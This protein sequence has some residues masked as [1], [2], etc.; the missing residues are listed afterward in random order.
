MLKMNKPTKYVV[1]ST[2]P[3][4]GKIEKNRKRTDRDKNI[5]NT[6]NPPDTIECISFSNV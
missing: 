2:F 5:N 3:A 4:W 1:F 6:T